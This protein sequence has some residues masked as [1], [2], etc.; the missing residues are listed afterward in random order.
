MIRA[1]VLAARPKTL[2]A[3]IVP[4]LMATALAAREGGRIHWWVAACALVG[5]V[6]I[7]I[8]TN[9]FN[10]AL[11]YEKGADTGERLGPVR[12]TQA[13]L[14]EPRTVKIAAAVCLLGAALCGIPLLYR[15]GWPLLAIGLSSMAL[16]YAYTGGPFPLA[17]HG[18]GELFVI[19]FFGVIAVGGTF[20]VLTLRWTG[21]AIAAGLA[22]GF[23]A[24]VLLVINNLR[25][26][27]GD[28]RSAKRTLAVRLGEGFAR[29]E[30]VVFSVLPFLL[31]TLMDRRLA[32]VN[33]ALPLAIALAARVHRGR[34]AEL[35]RSL[36]M[37]GAL[38]WVFGLLFVV[39]CL[40]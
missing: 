1:W 9:L 17:Y 34:G 35:N 28:R 2:S 32:I 12:V 3:A 5:A 24:S 25:D 40:L 14:L 7:Q 15:G 29:A 10:D 36:A 8:A 19:L 27:E 16:A 26:V 18:L 4:V 30:A 20:Y 31:V 39:G 21:E 6:L 37:A 23:L 33:L 13:G 11:D 22:A 38:Q